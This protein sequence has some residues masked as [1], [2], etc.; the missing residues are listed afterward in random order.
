MAKASSSEIAY[1]TTVGDKTQLPNGD[2]LHVA[3]HPNSADHSITVRTRRGVAMESKVEFKPISK[4]IATK[5]KEEGEVKA[6]KDRSTAN[7][8]AQLA[9]KRARSAENN[10]QNKP[11]KKK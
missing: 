2:T 5:K 7:K 3:R 6:R 10:N 8:A 4:V 1:A 9:K 11:G